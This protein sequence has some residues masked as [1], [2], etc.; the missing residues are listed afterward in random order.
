MSDSTQE[1]LF[2]TLALPRLNL[3]NLPFPIVST[4]FAFPPNLLR[5]LWVEIFWLQIPILKTFSNADC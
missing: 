4:L 3:F 2:K 1:L 5:A